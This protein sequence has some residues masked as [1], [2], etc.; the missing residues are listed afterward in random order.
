MK[1]ILLWSTVR[2]HGKFNKFTF[3]WN[4]VRNLFLICW[5]QKWKNQSQVTKYRASLFGGYHVTFRKMNKFRNIIL[6]A[7]Y[8][9]MKIEFNTSISTFHIHVY[10]ITWNS[11]WRSFTCTPDKLMEQAVEG[12]FQLHKLVPNLGP[13]PLCCIEH[14]RTPLRRLV[15][16][17]KGGGIAFHMNVSTTV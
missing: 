10:T 1:I 17:N 13:F 15:V 6:L 11:K 9:Y 4:E 3:T 16:N 5:K 12:F 8:M 7:M 14:C 2:R